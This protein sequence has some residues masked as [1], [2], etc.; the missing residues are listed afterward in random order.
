[1]HAHIVQAVAG[2]YRPPRPKWQTNQVLPHTMHLS[3]VLRTRSARCRCTQE[4]AEVHVGASPFRLVGVRLHN[5]N[6]YQRT[7]A[8]GISERF[9]VLIHRSSRS[10]RS[11]SSL[12]LKAGLGGRLGMT[13]TSEPAGLGPL[14]ESRP[15]SDAAVVTCSRARSCRKACRRVIGVGSRWAGWSVVAR[16][17]MSG[18]AEE[19]GWPSGM[20]SSNTRSIVR[21]GLV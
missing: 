12:S 1:M 5:T 4:R 16:C 10:G 18:A 21:G 11:S 9:R 13:I 14:G 15:S 6:N 20:T 8:D 7:Q 19:D 2:S 17:A 3:K